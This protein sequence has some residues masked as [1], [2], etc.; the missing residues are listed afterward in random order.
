MAFIVTP[1]WEGFMN[2]EKYNIKFKNEW[3][4]KERKWEA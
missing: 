1:S 3:Q 4:Q 2:F